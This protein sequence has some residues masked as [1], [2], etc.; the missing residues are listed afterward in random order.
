MNLVLI[1]HGY[2]ITIIQKA[3]R[4]KYYDTLEKAHFG[5][6]G[7]FANFVA[8]AVERSLNV[9]L[10]ALEPGKPLDERFMPL[11][12]AT[13]YCDYSQEYLSLLARR[14]LLDAMK[15]GRNWVTTKKAI[16]K[17]LERVDR[18]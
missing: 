16:N 17:Y 8:R 6:P 12:E 2:P 1:K 4:K 5:D 15:I 3:E 18:G 13:K 10:E 14:G 9:Y 11:A 7:P